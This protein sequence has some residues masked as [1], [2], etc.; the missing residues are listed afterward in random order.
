MAQR[1][2]EQ[3]SD[4]VGRETGRAVTRWAMSAEAFKNPAFRVAYEKAGVPVQDAPDDD[5]VAEL[6]KLSAAEQI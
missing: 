3:T 4:L 1:F 5:L 6:F 2:D